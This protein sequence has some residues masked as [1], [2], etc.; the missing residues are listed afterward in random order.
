MSG[1][2]IRIFGISFQLL[3]RL[4]PIPV[5]QGGFGPGKS[6]NMAGLA[7]NRAHMII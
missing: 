4:G 7:G 5:H 6:R 1:N 3:A 2:A